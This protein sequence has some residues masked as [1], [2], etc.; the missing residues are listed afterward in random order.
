MELSRAR[1]IVFA[2]L[3]SVL[4]SVGT[5]F[6]V[7]GVKIV[8]P[9]LAAATGVLFAGTIMWI[10]LI[11]TRQ[12]PRWRDLMQVRGPL[13]MLTLCRPIF[14][15]MLYTIG[16][17][18]ST[19]V[20]AVFLTKMEPYLVIFWVWLLDHKRPSSGHLA[21]LVVHII[22]AIML[23]T[24]G[25]SHEGAIS[26]HGD[27]II[28]GG[29]ITAALSYRYSPKVT[30]K[31]TAVQAATISETIG[32]L[33]TLPIALFLCPLVFDEAHRV[34]WMY[35]GVHAIMFYIFAVAL[36]YSS[37]K[38]IE[39]WLSSALRATGPVVAT[40]IALIFFG[41]SLEPIQAIGAL[42]VIVT[43]A[44]ISRGERKAKAVQVEQ[45]EQ[46]GG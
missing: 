32:G 17:S 40:P 29:V 23:S 44:L 12:L 20:E 46:A 16:I 34:G 1:C 28:V 7:E 14:A 8:P 15:N 30:V 24:G 33:F 39:G 6:K 36:L 4:S 2:V 26:W 3:S 22:G 42:I 43:S 31:L 45:I 13:L 21:M 18:M 41:D 10:Y 9:L 35:V 25:G 5:L 19:G 37:L 38:G 27:L 11:V